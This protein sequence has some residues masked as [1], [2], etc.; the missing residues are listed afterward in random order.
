M[1]VAGLWAFIN[2]ITAGLTYITS[3]DNPDAVKKAGERI[4][5]SLIGLVLVV[6]SFIIAAI[7]G[8]ILYG[9]SSAILSPK[10]YGPN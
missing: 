1:V 4:Y 7:M 6:G 9:D 5:M 3:G 10:I 8:W 2:L